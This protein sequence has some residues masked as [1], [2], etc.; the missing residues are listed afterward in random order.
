MVGLLGPAASGVV[1]L[2]G[3]QEVVDLLEVGAE[4]GD[5]V[6][7]IL[8]ADDAVLAKRL[9]N[10]GVVGQTSALTRDLAVSALVDKLADSL[11]GG[12]T[13]AQQGRKPQGSVIA[14]NQRYKCNAKQYP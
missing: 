4:R 1:Q 10:D 13:R 11:E 9:L 5:L 8:N 14:R 3:P 7:D 2:E 12:G 6:H